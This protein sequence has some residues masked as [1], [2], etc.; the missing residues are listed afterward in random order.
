MKLKIE[1][2]EERKERLGVW[3]DFFAFFPR[4]VAP[5]DLRMFEWIERRGKWITERGMN[6]SAHWQFEY[7]SKKDPHQPEAVRLPKPPPPR[8]GS[9]R[10]AVGAPSTI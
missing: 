10:I 2:L 1:S 5:G 6:R 3:H 8:D 7:R 9:I 4:E